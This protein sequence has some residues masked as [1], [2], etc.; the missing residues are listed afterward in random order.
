VKPRIDLQCLLA[1]ALL[2]GALTFAAP[3]WA[4]DGGEAPAVEAPGPAREGARL[5]AP[6]WTGDLDALL[7]RRVLRVLVTYSRTNF[8]LDGGALSGITAIT[9]QDFERWLNKRLKTGK[10]PINVVFIP[11]P[12]D[13]LLTALVEGQGDIAAASLTSTEGRDTLVDFADPVVANVNEV[14]VQ[15][16]HAPPLKHVE[17]LSGRRVYVRRSSSYDESLRRLNARLAAAGRKPVVIEEA[18]EQLESEDIMELVGAGVVDYT[19]VDG[20][21]AQLWAQVVPNVVVLDSL[22]LAADQHIGWA[23]RKESP[24][25]RELLNTF[26]AGY[27]QSGALTQLKKK[28]FGRPGYLK[29]PTASQELRRFNASVKHFKKYAQQYSLDYLLMTAQ[30]YQESKLNQAARSQRG[31]IGVMQLLPKTAA[32]API[33]LPHI[34]DLETNIHAGV[35]YHKHLIDTLFDDG[36]ITPQNRMLFAFAAYNAGPGNMARILRVTED[37]GLDKNKWFGNVEI[38]AGKVVGVETVRYVSNIYKYYVAYKLVAQREKERA[39]TMQ[40]Q[41]PAAPLSGAEQ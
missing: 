29:N 41:T 10:S 40:R 11:V 30:G 5:T 35:K 33:F 36:N 2:A 14:V 6:R 16:A 12:R 28:F 18:D 23:I 20:Q 26:L 13:E 31:A 8:F 17:D 25:L 15:G 22:V 21:R 38:A 3:A 32:S 34:Q 37:L 4:Q 9:F 24:N 1:T 27:K 19:V 7:K 39:G